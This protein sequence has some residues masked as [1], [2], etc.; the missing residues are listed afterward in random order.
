MIYVNLIEIGP[1]VIE[2][3]GVENG[4]LVVLVNNILVHRTSF[5]VANTQPC[6]DLDYLGPLEEVCKVKAA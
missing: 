2:I 4:D 6:V 3:L 1:V 5:L